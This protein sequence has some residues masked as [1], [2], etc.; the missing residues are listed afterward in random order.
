MAIIVSLRDQDFDGFCGYHE[1][2]LFV[3]QGRPNE[4]LQQ[5]AWY[6]SFLGLHSSPVPRRLLS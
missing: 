1:V 3:S 5:T 6:D 4:V 2:L